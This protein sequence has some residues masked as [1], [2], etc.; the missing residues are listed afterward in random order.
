MNLSRGSQVGK[1]IGISIEQENSLSQERRKLLLQEVY[2]QGI[3]NQ[4]N[5]L[6]GLLPSFEDCDLEEI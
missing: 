5:E 6:E 1:A 3:A 2:P 4:K